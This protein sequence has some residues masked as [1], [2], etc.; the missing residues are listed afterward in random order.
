MR[1]RLR[2]F[3]AQSIPSQR[4]AWGGV[5]LVGALCLSLAAGCGEAPDAPRASARAV[6]ATN[7]TFA[8]D[9]ACADC[10]ADRYDAYHRTGMG[11]SVSRFDTQTAPERL[12]SEAVYND[13][14]DLHYQA[15]LRGDS[16]VQREYRLDADGRVTYEREHAASHVI[17]SGNATRSYLMTAAGVVTEMPLTWY[18]ERETWDMSPAY[19]QRN[20]RFSRPITEPCMTCHNGPSEHD[21]G[22]D[23]RYETVAEGI[24]CE[25]CHG[26]ASAHVEARLEGRGPAPG[27]ADPTLPDLAALSR[28]RQLGVC[29][30]CHLTGV[31]VFRPGEAMLSYQPGEPLEEHRAVFA[32]EEQ[33]SDPERFGIAS[34]AKRLALSACFEETQMTCTTCHD[35][36]VPTAELGADAF[37]AV[38]QDCHA[39]DDDALS[40]M[41]AGLAEAA[42]TCSREEH[43]EAEAQASVDAAES[44]GCVDCH[45]GESGTS[46]IPHVTFT[47]HWIR[48]TLPAA[49]APEDIER[50]LIRETPLRLVRLTAPH[51]DRALADLETAVAYFEW[52]E[53]RHELPAYLDS[54]VARASSGFADGRADHAA[55]RLA[56]AR[57]LGAQGRT[58]DA[59]A[60]YAEASARFPREPVLHRFYGE[61][62]LE[63]GR[64]ARALAALDT[65][66]AAQPLAAPA[67]HLRARALQELRRPAESEAAYREALRLDPLHDP[68]AW[69]N[70]GF[71]LLEQQRLDDAEAALDRALALDPDLV[72]ALVNRATL[73][74]LRADLDDAA[75]LLDRALDLDP[76]Q[77]AALGNRALIHAERG[78]TSAARRLLTRLVRQ[79]PTDQ[80]ARALLQR[81]GG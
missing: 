64:P 32:S 14:F 73:A 34:H 36:H 59:L 25:R 52:Y 41:G 46:D 65:S 69:N 13:R 56:L 57:A 16:L 50:V 53:A 80:R 5:G 55:A 60:A 21:F 78:E 58:E 2:L 71:L 77:P 43:G 66:L 74:L 76:R 35:P 54:V 4:L 38:C 11:R 49:R 29:Q 31:L 3:F 20:L 62:L 45:M 7:A 17:G 28:E 47:D 75:T 33:V 6:P 8:G 10:H 15:F 42:P 24:T 79:D 48:R 12:P 70:L 1:A 22:T 27:E 72:L 81:L 63:A 44:P 67:H 51:D 23:A 61:A 37:D 40:A 26:P 39:L 9:E 19:R 18:V 68:S 30:Q